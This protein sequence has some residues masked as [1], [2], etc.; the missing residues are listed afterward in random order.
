M[1][2]PRLPAFTLIEL[3]VVIAIIA[4]LAA[5][6]L[7]ALAKAK[8]RA[9][10]VSC[11]NNLKQVG[12]AYITWINDNEKDNLPFR[13]AVEDGGTQGDPSPFINNI[14]WH[15]AFMANNLVSPRILS[16]PADIRPFHR[17]CEDWQTF[18]N[19]PSFRNNSVSY[20]LGLDCGVVGMDRN[21][22]AILSYEDSSENILSTDFNLQ[23]DTI[24]TRC[25]SG[26]KLSFEINI[27]PAKCKWTN[28]VHFPGGQ[29][30][31]LDGRVL[32]AR[33]SEL[34]ELLDNG[35]MEHGGDG[36]ADDPPVVHFLSP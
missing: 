2:P 29:A 34:D 5:L 12:L 36:D 14:W 32:A 1:K 21:R 13:V 31:M 33:N 20:T 3:L 27:Q 35:A 8:A 24:S 22:K 26:L 10:R 15:F 6:L 30:L 28:G 9:Q 18:T 17:P 19:S 25:S 7:P 16:C 23:H 11:I 4:I